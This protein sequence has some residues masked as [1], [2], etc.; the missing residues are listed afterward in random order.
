M[1]EGADAILRQV[2]RVRRRRN[3]H[4]IAGAVCA[5]IAVAAGVLVALVTFAL[6]AGS[7]PFAIACAILSAVLLFATGWLAV[8]AARNW[9]TPRRA[10][11]WIDRR[12]GLEGRLATLLELRP[13]A[14]DAFF[15]PLLEEE[16]RRRAS[17]WEP[18]RIVPEPVPRG[19]LAAAVVAL[20]AL[21]IVVVVAPRLAPVPRTVDA[22]EAAVHAAATRSGDLPA[23]AG[24]GGTEVATELGE[25]PD[26]QE[27][28]SV[29]SALQRRIRQGLWG[30]EPA[31]PPR[32]PRGRSTPR[33]EP[34]GVARE[35]SWQAAKGGAPP[36][37]RRMRRQE[38]MPPPA[39]IEAAADDGAET[40]PRPP[41]NAA[42]R[43]GADGGG[44][45]GAGTGTDPD[46]YGVARDQEGTP[47]D[48][49]E[50]GI[51]ARV[52]TRRAAARPPTGD[53]PPAAPDEHPVLGPRQRTEVAVR[54]MIVPPAYEPVVRKIYAHPEEDTP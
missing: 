52:R 36:R 33:T 24:R 41:E 30:D 8:R 28:T 22:D 27:A 16:N 39:Q 29:A 47:R 40:A 23:R 4:T 5:L 49:F 34:E 38:D 50:L 32:P 45:S 14:A 15:L 11:R 54:R 43:S 19:M 35:N 12:A 10:A 3:V 7:R 13:R 9:L 26:R 31:P 17:Q 46:L 42:G 20:T 51:A 37:Y 25:P 1:R 44:A 6:V 18:Q 2:A 48:R 53:T 21:A